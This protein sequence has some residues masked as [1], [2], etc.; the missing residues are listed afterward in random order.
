MKSDDNRANIFREDGAAFLRWGDLA[1]AEEAFLKALDS[2]NGHKDHQTLFKM[3]ELFLEKKDLRLALGY[4]VLALQANPGSGFYKQ[5]FLDVGGNT[6]FD[7]YDSDVEYALLQCLK[8]PGID[9]FGAAAL[10]LTILQSN[11]DFARL[12]A[13]PRIFEKKFD[14]APLLMPYFVEGLKKIS[15]HEPG[16]EDFIRRLRQWLLMGL[17]YPHKMPAQADY[18]RLADAVAAYCFHGDYIVRVTAPEQAKLRDV[19]KQPVDPLIAAIHACYS[20]HDVPTAFAP[21]SALAALLKENEQISAEASSIKDTKSEPGPVPDAQSLYPRWRFLPL[22]TLN[23]KYF[24]PRRKEKMER[25][26]AG[27]KAEVL[28]AGC[29]T[30]REALVAALYY[31]KGKVTAIDS[32]PENLAYAALKSREFNINN[33]E[34]RQDDTPSFGRDAKTYD[35]IYSGGLSFETKEP[36]KAWQLLWDRLKPAGVMKIGL[37][38]VTARRHVTAAREAAQKFNI[39]DSRESLRDFRNRSADF[40]PP[41]VQASLGREQ[42]YYSLPACRDMLFGSEHCFT[43][44]E[45]EEMLA[46]LRL[47]FTGFD[48]PVDILQ[49]YGEKFPDDEGMVSLKNWQA[50]EEEAPDTFADMYQFWCRK[51]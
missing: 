21:G 12:Y 49:R 20:F 42:D 37:H 30:G 2:E 10:W 50:F 25:T 36:L 40:L 26:F 44:P 1:E 28:A 31:P 27:N 17:S 4:Y 9:F 23:A 35:I 6:A 7:H 51:F 15:I 34:F 8:S 39:G 38:S 5:R 19:A 43:L 11:P 3:A 45:I 14:S 48:L 41:E 16:F 22:H 47:S 33:I 32:N 29:G 18:L 46:K 13:D 24:Y